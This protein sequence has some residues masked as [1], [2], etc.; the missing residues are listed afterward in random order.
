MVK[1]L[2]PEFPAVLINDFLGYCLYKHPAT[3]LPLKLKY[4]RCFLFGMKNRAF[5]QH[6]GFDPTSTYYWENGKRKP[7][8]KSIAK[9]SKI[10]GFEI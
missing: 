2:S 9:L 10:C 7:H 3:T 4:I 8:K 5:A 6:T 1:Q